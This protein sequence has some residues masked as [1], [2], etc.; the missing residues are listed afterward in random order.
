MIDCEGIKSRIEHFDVSHGLDCVVL[1]GWLLFADGAMRE[2]NPMGLLKEPKADAYECSKDVC[3]FYETKLFF[4]VE[5]FSTLKNNLLMRGRTALRLQNCPSP[6]DQETIFRL[7][8]LKKK[9]QAAQRKFS[10]AKKDMENL[11]PSFIRVNKKM[12][13][14]N[15][16]K[17]ADFVSR[18][19]EI[20]V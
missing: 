12:D 10:K 8:E 18:I 6:P 1:N 2:L 15:R 4:A 17:N 19:E 5:E 16:Q 14:E 7:A 20:E 13:D 3:L 11:I 9:V